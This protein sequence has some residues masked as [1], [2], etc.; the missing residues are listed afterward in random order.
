M[1]EN[2]IKK[3]DRRYLGL[4]K[5][6]AEWSKDPSTKV[7]AVIVDRRNRIVSLGFNGFPQVVPDYKRYLQDR[8]EKYL[9][10]IHAEVNAILFSNR[11]LNGH[12]IYT[13]PFAPCANCMNTIVQSGITRVVSLHIDEERRQRWES[14]LKVSY[15]IADLAGIDLVLYE[16]RFV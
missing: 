15:D 6:I 11:S 9:R 1:S 12:T 3:W 16:E 7:G 10:T 13:W 4:A 8:K 14:S 2:K 5:Y